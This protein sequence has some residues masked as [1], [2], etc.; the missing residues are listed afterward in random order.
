MGWQI[1]PALHVLAQARAAA[2]A[3]GT[4][5]ALDEAAEAAA[6]RGHLMTLNRVEADRDALLSAAR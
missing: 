5:A 4:K 3:P 1:P 6:S 2:G